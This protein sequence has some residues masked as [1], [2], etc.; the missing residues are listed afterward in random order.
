LTVGQRCAAVGLLYTA[1]SW[2]LHSLVAQ[3]AAG[4]KRFLLSFPILAANIVCPFFFCPRED[5]LARTSALF[6]ISWLA[7]FKV[8]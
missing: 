7:S 4:L 3:K 5:L 2:Y 8:R 6:I 1:F